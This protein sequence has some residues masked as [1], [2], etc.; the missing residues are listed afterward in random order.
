MILRHSVP[1]FCSIT[2]W[3][4]EMMSAQK[5]PLRPGARAS[6]MIGCRILPI[7]PSHIGMSA[8]RPL[9]GALP[10]T[11]RLKPW[12]KGGTAQAPRAWQPAQEHWAMPN[13][14]LTKPKQQAHGLWLLGYRAMCL[15]DAPWPSS[16]G[17][18]FFSKASSC[19]T[20]LQHLRFKASHLFCMVCIIIII[21]MKIYISEMPACLAQ[22]PSTR[23]PRSTLV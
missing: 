3:I 9:L 4:S 16:L 23:Q 22:S 18:G 2:L 17:P 6:R 20:S 12:A 1:N 21:S 7:P 19:S 13:E 11:W 10:L 15:A 5:K 14:H 8:S